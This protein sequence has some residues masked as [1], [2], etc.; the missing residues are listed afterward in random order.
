MFI[1]KNRNGLVNFEFLYSK[2]YFRIISNFLDFPFII[3][4]DFN[5]LNWHIPEFDIQ[6]W[7]FYLFNLFFFWYRISCTVM[8]SWNYYQT[9]I[10]FKNWYFCFWFDFLNIY[11]LRNSFLNTRFCNSI[12]IICWMVFSN[13]LIYRELNS[14]THTTYQCYKCSMWHYGI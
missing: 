14:S 11:I 4:I 3:N 6:H 10:M 9:R 2:F 5:Y 13:P 1:E 12:N 7:F 8:M